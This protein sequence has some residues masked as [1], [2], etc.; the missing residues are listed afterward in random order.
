M[1]KEKIKNI[2]KLDADDR[3]WYSIREIVKLE[4]VWAI[5]NDDS[6]VMFVDKNQDEIFPI[7]PHKE[8]AEIC[9]FEELKVKN[10]YI[11]PI[12]YNLFIKYCIPEM[13]ED[14]ILFGMFYDEERKAIVVSPQQLK[15]D[16]LNEYNE[17]VGEN[18]PQ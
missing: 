16:L 15:I 3:Y 18:M 9:V 7:W 12:K 5:S 6:W 2:L 11:K 1:H 14:H 8:V 10:Y 4:L 17:S 13:E